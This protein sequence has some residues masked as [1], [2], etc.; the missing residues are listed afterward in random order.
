MQDMQA[1]PMTI[2]AGI[3]IVHCCIVVVIVNIDI[4]HNYEHRTMG[5]VWM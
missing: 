5:K 1:D 2:L 4:V 3:I